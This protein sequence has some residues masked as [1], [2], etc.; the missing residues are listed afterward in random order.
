MKQNYD[1]VIV[2]GGAAGIGM[3][4]TLDFL[5]KANLKQNENAPSISFC[6]LERHEVGSSF[7]RWPK[8]M[9][10][11]S[12]SFLSNP[13]GLI[14]LNAISPDTSPAFTLD[15]EHPS[16]TEYAHYLKQIVKHF[17][18]P[19]YEGVSVAQIR[20]TESGYWVETLASPQ[21]MPNK[22]HAKAIIWAG[23]EFQHPKNKP[24]RGSEHCIHNSSIKTWTQL[25]GKEYVVIGGYESGIDAAI[26]LSKLNK[27][28]YVVASSPTWEKSSADPSLVLS[29]YTKGRLR[30]AMRTG[31]V[32][33]EGNVKV[34]S[35]DRVGNK[36]HLTACDQDGALKRMI[37][38]QAPILATG[39]ESSARQISHLFDWRLDG[40][41]LVN[42]M[43]E[44]T[45]HTG[46]FLVGPS[47]RHDQHIL[48][49][50]YKFRQRFAVVAH[51][52]AE[53]LVVDTSPLDEYRRQG[54]FLD[55]LSCCG[56][57]CTC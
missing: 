48:C 51:T 6:V 8:E 5:N 35:V 30:A 3:A 22:L 41:P 10:F 28:A 31:L 52:I 40:M 25:S 13:F 53:R 47:L 27:K 20:V 17:E 15:T 37:H 46:V 57:G 43:D 4:K 2:G 34:L 21:T 7:L 1:V 45:L 38:N 11:I 42:E 50:V 54:M 12:P 33:L 16:G 23:G 36:Y 26:Q 29:P 32:T 49:F 39:F 24:F 14:D 55:D 19:V 18:L 56:G 9:R 44:S